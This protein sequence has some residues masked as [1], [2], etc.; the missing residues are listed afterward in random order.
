M[1]RILAVAAPLLGGAAL[2]GAR[3]VLGQAILDKPPL[4]LNDPAIVKEGEELYG[5]PPD[6][7]FQPPTHPRRSGRSWRSSKG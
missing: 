7:G 3:P 6:A 2:P 1:L 5:Y 4:D